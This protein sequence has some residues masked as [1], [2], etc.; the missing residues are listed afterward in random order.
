MENEIQS[1]KDNFAKEKGYDSWN[2]MFYLLS[3]ARNYNKINHY[4]NEVMKILY[5]ILKESSL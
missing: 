5:N 2:H 4:H 1:I 3:C